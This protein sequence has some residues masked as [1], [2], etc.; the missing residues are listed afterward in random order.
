MFILIMRGFEHKGICTGRQAHY[1]LAS[2]H[3]NHYRAYVSLNSKDFSCKFSSITV[4]W[5]TLIRDSFFPV[6]NAFNGE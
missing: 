1:P 5:R 3:P 6:T 4:E 2:P